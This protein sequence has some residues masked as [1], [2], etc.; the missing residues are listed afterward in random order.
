MVRLNEQHAHLRTC[1]R[2]QFV[3]SGK[4]AL[5]PCTLYVARTTDVN[6][7]CEY[8]YILMI[9]SVVLLFRELGIIESISGQRCMCYSKDACCSIYDLK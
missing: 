6:S 1:N 2:T 4:I 8:Q 9:C 5:V 3:S 7:L